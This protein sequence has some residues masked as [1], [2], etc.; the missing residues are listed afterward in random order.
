MSPF[1]TLQDYYQLAHFPKGVLPLYVCESILKYNYSYHHHEFAEI[2]LTLEGTAQ[3]FINGV[4]HP[5][6]PG[7]FSFLMPYDIHALEQSQ[8]SGIRKYSCMFD[9]SLLNASEFNDLGK[10]LVNLGQSMSHH[11]VLDPVSF[12]NVKSIFKVLLHEFAM[13]GIEKNHFLKLKLFELIVN[14]IRCH[15]ELHRAGNIQPIENPEWKIIEYVHV[16]FLNES[17]SLKQLSTIFG[18]SEYLISK[19]FKQ[20]LNRSFIEYLHNLRVRRACSLLTCLE[21]PVIDIAYEVGFQS[22]RT[23]TRVFKDQMGITATEY[24]AK[25]VHR[26][27]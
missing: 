23:F 4:M 27:S 26:N 14:F 24:R 5:I 1:P 18:L 9:M 17:L 21:M 6:A 2:S 13:D 15:T 3:G 11:Y 7:T 10:W 8:A 12:E 19:A 22:L 25:M 16:H 20:L